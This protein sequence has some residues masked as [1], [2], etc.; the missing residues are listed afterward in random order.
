MT[1]GYFP[2]YATTPAAI[3]GSAEALE[4]SAVRLGD[5]QDAVHTAHRP[6]RTAVEGEISTVIA[7]APSQLDERIRRTAGASM[8]AVGALRFFGQAVRDHDG[9]MDDLETQWQSA[10]DSDFGVLPVPIYIPE[11]DAQATRLSELRAEHETQLAA[12]RDAKLTELL[13]RRGLAEAT[14]DDRS[15]DAAGY[16]TSPIGDALPDLF[17]AGHLPSRVP[18]MFPDLQFT[19]FALPS[20]VRD[21]SD[22]ELAEYALLHPEQATLLAPVLSDEARRLVAER[23]DD[24]TRAPYAVQALDEL[25]A[26]YGFSG[27]SALMLVWSGDVEGLPG[28]DLAER[29]RRQ[30]SLLDDAQVRDAVRSRIDDLGS[31]AGAADGATLRAAVDG[32]GQPGDVT[33]ALG[34]LS[35]ISVYGGWAQQAGETL[36][37]G[38]AGYLRAL[39]EDLEDNDGG[40]SMVFEVSDWLADNQEMESSLETPEVVAGQPT[41]R[42]SVITTTH[43]FASAEWM[44]QAYADGLLL[45]SDSALTPDGAARTGPTS[46]GYGYLPMSI[47]QEPYGEFRDLVV[48]HGTVQPGLLTAVEIGRMS[49]SAAS[50]AERADITTDDGLVRFLYENPQLP[51]EVHDWIA[52]NRPGVLELL[53][54]NWRLDQAGGPETMGACINSEGYLVG[55][56]GQTYYVSVPDQSP[57]AAVDPRGDTAMVPDTADGGWTTVDSR[58]GTYAVGEPAD[59]VRGVLA[60]VVAGDANPER[61]LEWRSIGADQDEYLLT[62]ADGSAE[63]DDGA[64]REPGFY[65]DGLEGGGSVDNPAASPNAKGMAGAVGMAVDAMR[66][67]NDAKLAEYDRH[68]AYQVMFQENDLEQR[69][70]VVVVRQ[71]QSD[72]DELRVMEA[73]GGFDQDGKLVPAGQR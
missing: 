35:L 62:Y 12:A 37:A 50:F 55:P 36:P 34:N 32:E 52:N 27:V 41:G 31:D 63:I 18:L 64:S 6:V 56:D 19:Y 21:L 49:E 10:L 69:R 15:A 45:L 3:E 51:S 57:A 72:G 46:L 67:I 23:I 43:D 58:T 11:N 44:R 48:E 38:G 71:V 29:L 24:M 14:L 42:T 39:Y 26:A 7:E 2:H 54:R 1:S 66:G 61:Q 33:D 17:A 20:D 68:V 4:R 16:L 73:Y 65:P 8:V 40:D 5:V 25:A 47:L 60:R 70:A 13:D 22:P 28:S 30:P 59:D 9:T 53:E